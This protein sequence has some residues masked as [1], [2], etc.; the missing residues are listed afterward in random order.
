MASWGPREDSGIAL[1]ASTALLVL[2]A[3]AAAWASNEPAL[4]IYAVSF[5][6][7][8]LYWSAYRYG[9]VSAPRLRHDAM[10]AKPISLAAFGW[11]VAQAVPSGWAVALA[12]AG[13]GLNA[14]AAWQ[15]G[16]DRTYYGWELG[17][18]PHR[19]VTGFPY[20][21]VR[22][23]ML[24]GN[25]MAFGGV[26]AT[27]AFRERWWALSAAHVLL[28]VGL[29]WMETRTTPR[30]GQA[31]PALARW[32]GPRRPVLTVAAC[33]VLG[34][35]A[36]AALSAL[37]TSGGSALRGIA[38]TAVGA[39]MAVHGGQIYARYLAAPAPRRTLRPQSPTRSNQ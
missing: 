16:A 35:A 10:I 14:A 5:W 2:V 34:G 13:F 3:A 38:W 29:L 15:L 26:L 22:H 31:E 23:P 19:R 32:L 7:Y 39:A 21:L 9:H 8:G 27:P 33:A 12:G 25:V 37:T 28:N 36:G 4:A 17:D 24:I 30:A 20:S 6:H 18:V 1:G 11:A